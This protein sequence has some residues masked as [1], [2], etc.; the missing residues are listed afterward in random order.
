VW[1]SSKE[2]EHFLK[3]LK[4]EG[5]ISPKE[6]YWEATARGYAFA[7]ATAAKALR[8]ST[9]EQL[10]ADIIGVGRSDMRPRPSN[11]PTLGDRSAPPIF[12]GLSAG[13]NLVISRSVMVGAATSAIWMRWS[14]L[15]KR[16]IR[17]EERI[18]ARIVILLE[19]CK[20]F[21]VQRFNEFEIKK[22]AGK[23]RNEGERG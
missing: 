9:A 4:N 5:L 18:K 8:K 12:S 23:R 20:D 6:G 11:V 3:E 10:V 17:H 2:V 21:S 1:L 16:R 13:P 7:M 14:V 19:A 15:P 22:H